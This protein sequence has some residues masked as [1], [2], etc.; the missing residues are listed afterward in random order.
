MPSSIGEAVWI[1]VS[2]SKTNERDSDSE[3]LASPQYLE[4]KSRNALLAH[5]SVK[6]WGCWW[7]NV[8]SENHV[9]LCCCLYKMTEKQGFLPP[10]CWVRKNRG[11]AAWFDSLLRSTPFKVQKDERQL[12][13]QLRIT[14]LCYLHP[15]LPV[16]LDLGRDHQVSKGSS[17]LSKELNRFEPNFQTPQQ[18]KVMFTTVQAGVA[19][20]QLLGRIHPL[21]SY[22]C[23]QSVS[24]PGDVLGLGFL[25]V[26]FLWVLHW[27]KK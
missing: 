2:V 15:L 25:F 27:F 21:V 6:W 11:L 18:Y 23:V 9:I 7:C 4:F 3:I 8:S 16:R 1:P 14:A 22:K 19:Q 12:I 5:S 24:N 17:L 20:T 26:C 13:N 10:M